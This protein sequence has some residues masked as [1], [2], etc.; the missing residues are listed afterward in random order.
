[1]VAGG[2]SCCISIM[3][4]EGGGG[5]GLGLRPDPKEWDGVLIKTL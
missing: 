2:S 5:V 1:M 4:K 3:L